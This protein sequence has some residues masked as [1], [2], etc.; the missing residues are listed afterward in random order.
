MA[1]ETLNLFN[2]N[3]NNVK[4]INGGRISPQRDSIIRDS[5]LT[6]ISKVISKHDRPDYISGKKTFNAVVVQDYSRSQPIAGTTLE[7]I[8]SAFGKQQDNIL[9]V[10]AIVPDVHDLV[11]PLPS[12][13][14]K[15]SLRGDG[16]QQKFVK[17]APIFQRIGSLNEPIQ[18]GSVIEVEFTNNEY[19]EGRIV[20]VVQ[21]NSIFDAAVQSAQKSFS[22]INESI[23]S[24]SDYSKTDTVSPSVSTKSVPTSTGCKTSY[25]QTP[26]Q[27]TIPSTEKLQYS[28]AINY[29]KANHP[30]V[31]IAVFAVMYAESSKSGNAFSSAGGNNFG[32]VQ[33]DCGSWGS[34]GSKISSQF[35]RTDSGGKLRMF[36]SFNSPYDF[37][38][39]MADRLRKKGFTSDPNQWT[40]TYINKWWSPANKAQYTSG[41]PTYNAK[42]SIFKTA[43]TKYNYS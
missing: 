11:T 19:T 33:T 7:G 14:S 17:L 38:D 15:E 20:S 2:I 29:L 8:M 13:L 28:D 24:L 5:S 3:Y 10:R 41:T 32:G 39:F 42:L 30:D 36:A 40:D 31:G 37:L 23:G 27:E 22:E 16:E 12:N 18:V 4:N 1:D 6:E 43:S 9:Q 26:I 25:S 35:C 21:G 34:A